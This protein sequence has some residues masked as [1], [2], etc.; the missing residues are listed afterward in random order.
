MFTKDIS[1]EGLVSKIHKELIQLNVK[2]QTILFE[3]GQRTWI[4]IFP[5]KIYNRPMKRCSTSLI[6]RKMQIKTTMRYHLTPVRMAV[7]KKTT[8]N[9]CWQGCGE[10][11]TLVYYWWNY[12]LVQPLWK[13]VWRFLKKFKIELPY[14]SAILLLDIYPKKTK[15]L[16]WKDICTS[17]FIVALL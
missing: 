12:K 5:K 10:K 1:E 13:I 16:V 3:N 4:D 8:N 7:I 17:I 14:D 9:K 15:A 2:K 11:R 6:I